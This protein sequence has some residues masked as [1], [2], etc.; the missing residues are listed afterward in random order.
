MPLQPN[1]KPQII[2][3][4]VEVVSY[5]TSFVRFVVMTCCA[6]SMTSLS[7]Q[8]A[9]IVPTL[10]PL[11]RT[12]IRA[13]GRRYAE[14]STLT[15]VMPF[16]VSLRTR[17]DASILKFSRQLYLDFCGNKTASDT[18]HLYCVGNALRID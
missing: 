15:T 18:L 16:I 2:S 8:P 12:N 14:P 10:A 7:R 9:L 3:S 17:P 4:L 5:S 11:S 6:C 13:P 1:P